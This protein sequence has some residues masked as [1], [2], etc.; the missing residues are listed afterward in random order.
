MR[1]SVEKSPAWVICLLTGVP[2]GAAMGT[3]SKIDGS[4]LK[5]AVIGGVLIGFLFGTTMAFTLRR[6]RKLLVRAVGPDT[7]P[8]DRRAAG[9]ALRRG[10]V[11]ADP[12]VR[13]AAIRLARHQ[14][15]LLLHWRTRSL[16]C[17]SSPTSSS[18]RRC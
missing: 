7:S 16:T 9:R 11:P 6:Q 17:S 5:F 8:V 12:E 2:F 4:S 18:A 15:D 1:V 13:A 10:P 3:Y 14:L